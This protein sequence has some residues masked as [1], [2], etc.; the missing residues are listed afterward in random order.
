MYI[1]TVFSGLPIWGP[2]ESRFKSSFRSFGSDPR[3]L[4]GKSSLAYGVCMDDIGSRNLGPTFS[5]DPES[6][7]CN[8]ERK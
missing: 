8:S 4:G 3:L 7:A 6:L 1:P 5:S 2:H